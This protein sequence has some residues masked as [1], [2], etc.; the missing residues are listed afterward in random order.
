MYFIYLA[1]RSKAKGLTAHTAGTLPRLI[2]PEFQKVYYL[3]L[4]K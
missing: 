4:G 1:V 3:E 2:L